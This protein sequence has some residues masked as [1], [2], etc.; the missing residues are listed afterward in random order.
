MNEKNYKKS[1]KHAEKALKIE[2]LNT[3][4]LS[5]KIVA[6]YNLLALDEHIE[7][8]QEEWKQ[9]VKAIVKSEDKEGLWRHLAKLV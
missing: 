7:I 5:L 1:L 4:A 8:P 3:S 2:P 6:S 9:I